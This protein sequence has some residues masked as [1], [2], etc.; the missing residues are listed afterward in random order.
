MI[1]RTLAQV[2]GS[3]RDISWGNGQSRRIL[4]E[5]DNMGFAFCD[6]TVLAGT[7]S[8]IQYRHH[9]M[10]GY[11]I[12]GRGELEDMDGKVF[13]LEPGV[14]YAL[15]QHDRYRLRAST[16]LRIVCVFNPPISGE[17]RHHFEG[18]QGSSY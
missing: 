6:T 17:E 2:V 9:L 5:R 7:E 11:C 12:E 14:L 4:I 1:V 18:S 3:E 10:A 13:Q 8:V 15:D 16:D